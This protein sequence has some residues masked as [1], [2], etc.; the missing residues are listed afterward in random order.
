MQF[1]DAVALCARDSEFR[2]RLE[3]RSANDRTLGLGVS[4]SSNLLLVLTATTMVKVSL[5]LEKIQEFTPE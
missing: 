3:L 2:D 1:G 4:L 5:D